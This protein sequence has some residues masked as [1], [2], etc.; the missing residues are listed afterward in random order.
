MNWLTTTPT[1]H[2][3][4]LGVAL[5]IPAPVLRDLLAQVAHAVACDEKNSDVLDQL[6]QLAEELD[7]TPAPGGDQVPD[8]T[9]LDNQIAALADELLDQVA[10]V[11]LR[12]SAADARTLAEALTSSGIGGRS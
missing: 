4:P 12:M 10:P 11:E 3:T 5:R 6:G 7:D 9:S 1:V 8:T 2:R